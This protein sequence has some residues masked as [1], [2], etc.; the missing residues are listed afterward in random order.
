[1]GLALCVAGLAHGQEVTAE[2]PVPGTTEMRRV[3]QILGSTVR[4]NDGSSYGTVEDI[5]IGP[6]NQVDYLIVSHDR[7]YA[8]LPWVVGQFNPGQ[9]IVVYD[10]APLAIQPLLFPGNAWPSF[11][12]P[13]FTRRIQSIFPGMTR[14]EI[15]PMKRGSLR[16]ARPPFPGAAAVPPSPTADVKT[17]LKPAPTPSPGAAVVPPSAT[18]NVKTKKR[19]LKKP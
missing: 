5:V 8:A 12:D 4:L 1:L 17:P 7:Q 6:D 9:R 16:P 3:S 19:E 11:A 18:D 13:V 15:R 14:R 2:R 10:V